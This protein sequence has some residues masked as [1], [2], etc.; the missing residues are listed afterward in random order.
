MMYRYPFLFIYFLKTSKL[1]NK[2]FA[3][4]ESLKVGSDKK[5]VVVHMTKCNKILPGM[6]ECRLGQ[7]TM[8]LCEKFELS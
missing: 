3:F 6:V 2:H 8:S 7:S 5:T 4:I 1:L